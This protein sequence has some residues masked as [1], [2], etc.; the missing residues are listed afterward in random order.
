MN[1]SFSMEVHNMGNLENLL[2][3]LPPVVARNQIPFYL[4]GL[5]S[6]GTMQNFD[7]E[8]RGP[9]RI[10]IGRRVG[11]LREDLVEWLK[12]RMVKE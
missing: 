6:K 2:T 1:E 11:Y 4:G 9:K 8:G 7:S 12:S 10:V 3:S 5:L